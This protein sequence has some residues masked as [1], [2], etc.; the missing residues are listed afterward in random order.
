MSLNYQIGKMDVSAAKMWLAKR[1]MDLPEEAFSDFQSCLATPTVSS[2]T[3]F[4]ARWVDEDLQERLYT[5]IR[6]ARHRRERKRINLT[7]SPETYDKLKDLSVWIPRGPMPSV[8]RYLEW[9]V[10]KEWN[11]VT[12]SR[13]RV[14]L[15][16]EGVSGGEKVGR[17]QKNDTKKGLRRLP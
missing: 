10:K 7:I 6:V 8:T 17:K 11:E 13:R 16:I 3:K 12:G 1:V 2:L 9:L 4:I 5:T 14:G 15:D